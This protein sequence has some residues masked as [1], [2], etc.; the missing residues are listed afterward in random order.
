MEMGRFPPRASVVQKQPS[1]S[2][3][4][5]KSLT[6]RNLQLGRVTQHEK[7]VTGLRWSLE[8]LSKRLLR[9][10]TGHLPLW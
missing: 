8:T 10:D 9:G 4:Q 3:S 1:R 2:S 5:G 7:A 6:H